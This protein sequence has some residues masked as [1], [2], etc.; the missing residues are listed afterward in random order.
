MATAVVEVMGEPCPC[1]PLHGRSGGRRR[2]RQ[3]WQVHGVRIDGALCWSVKTDRMSKIYRSADALELSSTLWPIGTATGC[4]VGGYSLGS[5]RLNQG[6]GVVPNTTPTSTVTASK[7][8]LLGE[9]TVR[10]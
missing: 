6:T 1:T 8:V 3:A 2:W 5:T 4:A 9:C 10:A 7:P